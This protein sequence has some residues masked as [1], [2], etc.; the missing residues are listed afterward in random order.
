MFSNT[1]YQALYQFIGLGLHSKFI[2]IIT[3]ES[4][5]KGLIV[6]LF[7][8]GFFITTLKFISKYIP[9]SLIERHPVPLSKFIKVV[10]CLF[11]GLTI[12]RVGANTQVKDYKSQ[13]WANN[14]YVQNHLD[15]AISDYRVSFVFDLLSGTAQEVTALIS[16]AIDAVFAKGNS[17]LTAPDFFYKAIMY[18]GISTIQDQGLRNKLKFY[19]DECFTK[20][21]AD[22][23]KHYNNS[24][25]NQFF[26]IGGEADQ[27]LSDVELE[28]GNG[29]KT[30]CYK[31]KEN[32]RQD[33]VDYAS[34]EVGGLPQSLKENALGSFFDS[35]TYYNYTASMQLAN[36][37]QESQEG[38]LGI[39]KVAEVQG[40]AGSIFQTLG[41]LMSWDGL[42][43]MMGAKDL[44]GASEAAKRSQEF[45]EHL[46][47]APHVAGFVQML[48][49]A[50][51]P[52]L[53]FFVVAGQWR[54][55]VAW[56]WIYFSV[57]L[58][59]PL[60]T[61]LY[62]VMLGITMSTE[63]MQAFGELNEGVSLYSAELINHRIY[64]MY[65]IYA[66]VQLLVATMTTGSVFMFLKP[67]L[68]ESD[69]ESKPEFLDSAQSAAQTTAGVA[70]AVL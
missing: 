47:R 45:S 27:K 65:S 68:G 69:G 40:T 37:Y 13:N 5:F 12:L 61:L 20:V 60:W 43:G 26:R 33:F 56:F 63:I 55:L 58:W 54:V 48:L 30:D 59:V 8:A 62:H 17:Q 35:H 36:F 52:W 10:I 1:A 25:L 34:E 51:F 21:L 15:K 42:L 14:P 3:S 19:T 18:G 2:E 11:L 4:F 64:Y 67:M 28:L 24:S 46:S 50:V 49:I 57:L 16:R 70:K 41:R 23:E 38:R 66:W 53:M 32:V 22:G 29:Q 44:Q 39:Q 7:G 9:G 31:V 6:L